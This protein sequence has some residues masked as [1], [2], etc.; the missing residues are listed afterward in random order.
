MTI[1]QM[2]TIISVDAGK[3]YLISG[4]A[5]ADHVGI[6][7]TVGPTSERISNARLNHNR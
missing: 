5:E 1:L 2:D 3:N 6:P 7:T 4:D